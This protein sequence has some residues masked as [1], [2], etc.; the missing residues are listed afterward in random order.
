MKKYSQTR[1]KREKPTFNVGR[2]LLLCLLLMVH[3]P[4]TRANESLLLLQSTRV[5]INLINKPLTTLFKTLEKESEYVFFFK[6]DVLRN[7]VIPTMNDQKLHIQDLN[8]QNP[9]EESVIHL[10]Q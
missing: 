8:K 10:G 7:H 9:K 5:S 4:K 2:I 6:D 3:L 1:S